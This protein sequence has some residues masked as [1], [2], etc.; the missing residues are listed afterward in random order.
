M[1]NLTLISIHFYRTGQKQQRHLFEEHLQ[2]MPIAQI[3]III[4]HTAIVI[5]FLNLSMKIKDLHFRLSVSLYKE[6]KNRIFHTKFDLKRCFTRKMVKMGKMDYNNIK[7]AI[8]VLHS[9]KRKSLK[10]KNFQKLNHFN[11]NKWITLYDAILKH[12]R[13]NI[14]ENSNRKEAATCL[15]SFVVRIRLTQFPFKY[16]SEPNTFTD[17]QCCI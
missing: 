15:T 6:M 1:Q 5:N 3:L 17:I 2:Q 11:M 8:F 14:F 10:I 4:T 9:D 16:I 13:C 7:M 12:T